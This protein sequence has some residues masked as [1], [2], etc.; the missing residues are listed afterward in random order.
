MPDTPC[1]LSTDVNNDS[2]FSLAYKK[3]APPVIVAGGAQICISRCSNRCR[4]QLAKVDAPQ[5]WGMRHRLFFCQRSYRNAK[6]AVAALA[7]SAKAALVALWGC[8][9]R[10]YLRER[11]YFRQADFVVRR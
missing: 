7:T 10:V 1:G 5:L 2:A 9:Q 11:N 6:Q 3:A 4:L 8:N